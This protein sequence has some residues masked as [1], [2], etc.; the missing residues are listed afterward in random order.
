MSNDY[1]LEELLQ[2][3]EW[4]RIAPSWKATDDEKLEG[5]R[6]FCS[7]YWWIRHPERGRIHF[8]LFGPDPLTHRP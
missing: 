2:E 8:E 7:H 3:R 4:R 1:N 5:F 6:Y